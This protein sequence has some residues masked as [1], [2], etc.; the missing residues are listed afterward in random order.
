MSAVDRRR[1]RR[2]A[3]PVDRRRRRRVDEPGRRRRRCG[4]RRA[5]AASDGLAQ[6]PLEGG[7][8][9]DE[10]REVLVAGLRLAE[11][12]GQ[13]QR[14]CSRPAS[15]SS[16]T[17]GKRSRSVTARRARK[18]WVWWTCGAPRRSASERLLGVGGG[19]QRVAL[20]H[21]DLVAGAAEGER[22]ASPPTPPPT[23]T[24]LLRSAA[25]RATLRYGNGRCQL[26]LAS[27]QPSR[28]AGLALRTARPQRRA[29]LLDAAFDLL[30]TEGWD[31]HDGAGRVRAGRSSTRA[32]STRA[33]RTSTSSSS[34]STTAWSRSWAVEVL[35]AVAEAGRPTRARR[36]AR[37]S[38]RI[39]AF[40]DE[41]RRRGRVLYVEALGN[42]ALNRR[43]YRS[44]PGL[45]AFF[46]NYAVERYG[47]A[48]FEHVGASPPPS[49]SAA[50]ASCSSTGSP[51]GSRSPA[52]SSSTTPPAVPRLGRRNAALIL[53][54]GGRRD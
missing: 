31:G 39:V 24:T 37:S 16:S 3:T 26:R 36:P 19:R 27:P 47:E 35:A 1:R 25:R 51:A 52:T 49:S 9:H 33:S 13:R 42:E 22:G 38:S 8:A 6:H 53:D 15:R 17:S 29:L 34:P 23:M 48:R 20:E 50:S 7:A 46:E 28:W 43:R 10:H 21:R 44:R 14:R 12:G 11:V 45:V 40:V 54:S 41:D 2:G 4:P 32:T 5:A 18:P 30:G